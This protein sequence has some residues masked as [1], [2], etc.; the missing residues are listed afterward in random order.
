MPTPADAA[1][2]G[3]AFGLGTPF[4]EQLAFF[5][6]KLNLPSER[7]DDIRKAAHNRAFIVAG[8]AQADLVQDL[9]QAVDQAMARGVGIGEFRRSFKAVVAKNGWTGWRG[10]GSAAGVAWRTRVIYQ[11]N[12]ATSYAAGRWQ[13]LNDPDVAAA[14][15]FW[16]YVH[17]DGVL[18]PRPL[19][20]AWH[21]TVLPREH[22]FWKT[23]FAPNGWGCHCEVRPVKAPGPGDKTAP[24]AGWDAVN[25]ATG[26]PPGIDRGWDYA[27]GA[28]AAA[29]LQQLLDRKLIELDASIGAAMAQALQP[30]LAME[31][32]AAWWEAL[33]EWLAD[34]HA[35]KRRAVV[36]ALHPS[37]LQQLLEL[38]HA[39]PKSAAIE[40]E[41]GLVRGPKQQRHE[42]AQNALTV[43]EWRALPTLLAAPQRLFLDLKNTALLYLSSGPAVAKV[44][45]RLNLG[46]AGAAKVVSAFKVSEVDVASAVKAEQWQTLEAPELPAGGA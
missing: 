27:P 46:S 25:P 8:A 6:R 42:R 14:R 10:E 17:A 23:H 31:R 26:A 30:A 22:P 9:R 43:A 32:Q 44:A 29:P 18:H 24:P 45:V 38:G 20:L 12:M 36:G 16:R 41:D 4:E 11:T 34:E 7:W 5:R 33:D 37:T 40:V 2:P 1:D 15:P 39:A 3:A 35:R 21:N 19:H 28:D 13:Q